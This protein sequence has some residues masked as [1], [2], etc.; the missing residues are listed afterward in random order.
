[1]LKPLT[2]ACLLPIVTLSVLATDARAQ[3]FGSSAARDIEQGA[4]VARLVEQQIGLYSMP[5]R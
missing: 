3:L 1:M 4:E 2:C 5:E